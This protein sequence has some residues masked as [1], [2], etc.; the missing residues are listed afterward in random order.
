MAGPD[1]ADSRQGSGIRGNGCFGVETAAASE[2]RSCV[3][4][5]A[6]DLDN[7]KPKC[8]QGDDGR[9]SMPNGESRT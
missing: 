2:Y 8:K 3:L 6:H 1:M 9:F 5:Y 7:V 4:I